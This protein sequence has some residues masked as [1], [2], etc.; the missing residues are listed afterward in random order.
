MW[1]LFRLTQFERFRKEYKLFSPGLVPILRHV[2]RVGGILPVAPDD[3]R[4]ATRP[5]NSSEDTACIPGVR[6]L[7][8]VTSILFSSFL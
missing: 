7:H 1:G 6:P 2:L 3:A 5:P 8:E 4:E